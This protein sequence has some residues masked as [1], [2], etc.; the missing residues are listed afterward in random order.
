MSLTFYFTLI[1]W[2]KLWVFAL[3]IILTELLFI[4]YFAYSEF[5][6]SVNLFLFLE[7]FALI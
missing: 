2:P 5:E 3:T 7:L 6:L 4:P 1:I